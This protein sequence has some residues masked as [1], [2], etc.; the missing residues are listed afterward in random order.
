MRTLLDFGQPRKVRGYGHITLVPAAL[1]RPDKSWAAMLAVQVNGITAELAEVP[2]C[3]SRGRRTALSTAAGIA[4]RS[5][6]AG[7]YSAGRAVA[8][9]GAVARERAR[10][11]GDFVPD[12]EGNE[13]RRAPRRR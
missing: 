11:S 6:R 1:R 2:W 3:Y 13:V 7:V 4:R 8:I 12:G 5:A 10:N 9:D